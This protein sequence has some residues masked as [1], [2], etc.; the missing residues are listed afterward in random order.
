MRSR[1]SRFREGCGLLA[2]SLVTLIPAR[3][4][5]QACCAGGSIVTPGRLELHEDAL[6]GLQAKASSVFGSYD[7]AGR[8][9][10][11]PG[12]DTELDFEQDL[13]GALRLLRRGQIA[14]LVPIVETRRATPQQGAQFGGGVGDVNASARWDFI[15]AGQSRFVPGIALLAGLTFPT[16]RPPEQA[17]PPLFVDS[18]GI[19]AFQINAA[20]AL[21]QTF[22]AWLLNATVLGAKRA[23]HGGQ[24]LGTQVTLL[25]AAAYTFANDV[26]LALS[27]SYAFEGDATTRS[28]ADVPL[29]AHHVTTV[30]VSG[31]LPL[32]DTFRLLGGLSLTPPVDS[33]GS[34]QPASAGLSLTVLHSWS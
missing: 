8:Y 24:T 29:S 14:L 10:A 9:V 22:G 33:L 13:F 17:S 2:A 26:A 20:L 15:E 32:G 6:V 23:E 28:G 5:A 25:S 30:T 7:T 21:E 3:A 18:T 11:A 27:A 19:G 1:R 31:L 16:G 4:F 34:T 12:G